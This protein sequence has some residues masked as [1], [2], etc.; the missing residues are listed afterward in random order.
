MTKLVFTLSGSPIATVH[1]GCVPPVGSAVIIRTDN[2]KKGLVPGSLIR[3]TVEGEHCDPAVFDFTEK[4]TTVYFDVNG[5][6][7]LEKGP[8]LDR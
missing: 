4:N 6:E 2:Y 5:Y 7:L 3:F 1:A 8:P